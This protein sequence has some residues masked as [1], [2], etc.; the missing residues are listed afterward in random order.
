MGVSI[1]MEFKQVEARRH[2]LPRLV[3]AVPSE[4][5]DTR[6]DGLRVLGERVAGQ[7]VEPQMPRARFEDV[8][9]VGADGEHIVYTVTVGRQHLIVEDDVEQKVAGDGQTDDVGTAG[10]LIGSIP[11]INALAAG[12]LGARILDEKD[13]GSGLLKY[14]GGK[15]QF[16]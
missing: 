15:A 13:A 10:Y 6:R 3:A 16:D 8:D 12:V 2:Q 4:V 11:G 7:V 9:H 5:L 1:K 14:L